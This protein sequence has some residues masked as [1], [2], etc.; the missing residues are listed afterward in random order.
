M[1]K[2]HPHDS[3][4]PSDGGR[5]AERRVEELADEFLE[6]LLAGEAPDRQAMLSAHLDLA[7]LLELRLALVELMHRVARAEKKAGDEPR[8][9]RRRPAARGRP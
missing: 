1:S 9:G 8:A 3:S 7:G 5:D 4:I 2:Q 6:R